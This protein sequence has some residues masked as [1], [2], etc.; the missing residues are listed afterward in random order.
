MKKIAL[1]IVLIALLTIADMLS[2]CGSVSIITDSGALTTQEYNFI[3]FTGIE[4]GH[5]FE[6]EVTP[7]DTYGVTIT[8]GKNILE[9]INVSK[10]GSILKIDMDN[11]LFNFHNIPKATITMPDPQGL[12]LSGA[13]KGTAQGFYSSHDFKL[14]LSGASTLDMD[15]ETGNFESEISGASKL[16]G[17]LK[18]SSSSIELSGAS[19][20]KLTGAGGNIIVNGSG[21]SQAELTDFT[22][23]D[24]NI[25]LSGASH[26][27]LDINGKM[28]ASLSGASSLEYGGNPTLGKLDVTGASEIKQKSQ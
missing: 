16:T 15:M 21:A 22:V 4:I 24:A 5:A 10:S 19:Q 9:H 14:S 26:A 23:N 17:N 1:A 13:S 2:G 6:L 18:A 11:L 3:G 25:E 7:S 27:S 28:D 12:N 8:A 20:A